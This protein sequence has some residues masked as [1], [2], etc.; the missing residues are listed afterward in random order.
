[1]KVTAR[2]LAPLEPGGEPRVA[3]EVFMTK[4]EATL[5]TFEQPLTNREEAIQAA[6]EEHLQ[7]GFR[8]SREV[9]KG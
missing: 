8:C 9:R 4:A 7:R 5:W 2:K 1:M 6:L 3:L